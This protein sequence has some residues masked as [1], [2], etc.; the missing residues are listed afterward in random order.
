MH[1]L[2]V[3]KIRSEMSMRV[4]N[5]GWSR[6]ICFGLHCIEGGTSAEM[7]DH[8]KNQFLSAYGYLENYALKEIKK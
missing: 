3:D 6:S 2:K 7:S 8:D 5:D 1:E 4:V